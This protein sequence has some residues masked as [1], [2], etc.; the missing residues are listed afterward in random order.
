MEPLGA[1]NHMG[2]Y[3]GAS[4]IKIVL[5]KIANYTLDSPTIEKMEPTKQIDIA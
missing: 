3:T 5:T 1:I 4:F 2:S